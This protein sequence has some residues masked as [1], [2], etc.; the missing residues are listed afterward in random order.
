MPKI[1]VIVTTFNRE[2]LLEKT[3]TSILNQTFKD[4]EL[5]LVDNYSNYNFYDLVTKINDSR[6]IPFQN[7]NNGIIAVNRN[8][9]I[10][11]AKG[12]FIAFCDD[13]DL[14]HPEKLEI[15]LNNFQINPNLLLSSTD[16]TVID[17]QDNELDIRYKIWR[18]FKDDY[19]NLLISNHIFLSSVMIKKCDLNIDDLFSI[20]KELMTVEDYDLWLRLTYNSETIFLNQRLVYYRVHST[21][22]SVKYSIGAKKN[23]N[24]FINLFKSKKQVFF[25]KFLA[26]FFAYFKLIFYTLSG[27]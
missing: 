11:K 17:S 21:N 3:I 1:S 23:I 26:Y 5:I 19:K 27:K 7:H 2:Y 10:K 6:I 25:N 16:R 12:E 20:D 13:D 9:G 14:W 22:S 18:P 15:Q 8:F 4:I 24:I